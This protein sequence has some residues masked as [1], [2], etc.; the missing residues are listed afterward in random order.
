MEDE[1]DPTIGDI[2]HAV[3]T[4]STNVATNEQKLATALTSIAAILQPAASAISVSVGSSSTLYKMLGS[5]LEEPF[6]HT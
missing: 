6:P 2:M 5:S 1:S 3:G 4:L